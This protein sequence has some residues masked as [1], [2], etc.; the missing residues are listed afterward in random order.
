MTVDGKAQDQLT[1]ELQEFIT[2][3]QTGN[4]PRVSGRDGLA[5]ID[6]AERI[7]TAIREHCWDGTQA[8]PKGPFALPTPGGLLFPHRVEQEVA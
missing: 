1:C 4:T 2:C 7:I 3:V 5:A 8:G 6:V